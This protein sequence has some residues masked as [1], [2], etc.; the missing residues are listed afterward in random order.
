[1]KSVCLI[2]ARGGS[3]RIARKN[4]KSFFGKPLISWAIETAISSG[5]FDEV[6]VS[7]DDEEIASISKHY[8]ASSSWQFYTDGSGD[9][10][11]LKFVYQRSDGGGSATIT[12]GTV[13]RGQ[14][15]HVAVARNGSKLKL[16]VNGLMSEHDMVSELRDPSSPVNVLIG[17]EYI[18]GSHSNQ[19]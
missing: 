15:T 8:G 5:I 13:E 14:W 7:T 17:T 18:G 12:G 3:K 6:Y 10:S 9:T 11:T 2:P 1:M 19:Y 4:I 16:F